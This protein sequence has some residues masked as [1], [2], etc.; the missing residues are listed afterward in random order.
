M[1]AAVIGHVEW[2]EF[3][4]VESVP[5][6]GEIVHASDD[7]GRGG[8]WRSRRGGAAGEPRLRDPFFT[9]LGD[10]ELGR[11]SQA[12]LESRGVQLHV[13]WV[14][15]P[16]R[17]AVTYVDDAG[18]RTITVIGEKLQPRGYDDSLPWEELHR[19]D[20]VYFTGG[21]VQALAKARHARVLVATAR[22]L[23]T[24]SRAAIE[25]D[26]LVSSA[27]D[28]GERYEPGD[29]DPPPRLV[30]AT[31]GQ[32]GGWARPG[33]PFG[34]VTPPGP[35][36]DA[37]GAGDCFAAGLTYALASGEEPRDALT[38]AAHCG[39]TVVTGRGPYERQ[40]TGSSLDAGLRREL[41]VPAARPGTSAPSPPHVCAT[42][43]TRCAGARR[44]SACHLPSR[45]AARRESR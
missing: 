20:C 31:S 36:V 4:R 9:A 11:R 13:A 6:P 41:L 8:R 24:I 19:S 1:R 23:L 29:L 5:K 12:E 39:A 38:F 10:D 22:E 14:R 28:V 45:R 33:G 7:L 27:T 35:I 15:E 18:E 44:C 37:Y 3:I 26:A 42:P 21:D 40:L 16:Q 25:L 2:I 17:R 30:V 32:L 34:A 43:P